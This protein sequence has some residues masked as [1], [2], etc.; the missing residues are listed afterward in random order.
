MSSQRLVVL[1]EQD[2][3]NLIDQAKHPQLTVESPDTS[4]H[5]SESLVQGPEA[6]NPTTPESPS[7]IQLPA[8]AAQPEPGQ[9]PEP[10]T[11]TDTPEPPKFPEPTDK[12]PAAD[13]PKEVDKSPLEKL[14]EKIPKS[15]HK[16]AL[17]L[18][19]RLSKLDSF[20]YDVNTG[21]IKLNG[22]PLKNYN[23]QK[24]LVAT[25]KISASNDLP[26]PLRLFL[27]RNKI[28]KFR[29]PNIRLRPTEKWT[30][31]HD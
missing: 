21:E 3:K 31:F 14:L 28:T 25:S 16:K 30:S 29:N 8:E 26:I 17:N 6:T 4:S 9:A 24:F 19:D 15:A 7:P 20:G 27:H 22:K 12:G 2:Y 10:V 5:Q 11:D 1:D 18:L 23:L 13:E